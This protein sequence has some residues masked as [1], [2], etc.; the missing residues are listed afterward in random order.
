M[1]VW[2]ILRT[3]VPTFFCH[4]GFLTNNFD[5]LSAG[6]GAR[7]Q[8]IHMFIAWGFSINTE[9]TI[10]IWENICFRTKAVLVGATLEHSGSSLYVLPH[11]I[12]SSELETIWKMINL[13]IFRSVFEHL[14]LADTRPYDVPFPTIWWAYSNASSLHSVNNRIINMSRIMNFETK[15]H[16]LIKHFVIVNYFQ[17]LLLVL[18]NFVGKVLM[19]EERVLSVEFVTICRIREQN[20][21]L[22]SVCFQNIWNN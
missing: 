5:S 19:N 12:F 20:S 7:F 4:L 3:N 8:Y 2:D 11:Q 6:A 14:W 1:W 21:H 16:I 17:N 22:F 18:T 10:I 13:L 15:S 9:F